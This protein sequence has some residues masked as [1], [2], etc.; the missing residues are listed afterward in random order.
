M[1]WLLRYQ[2]V[3]TEAVYSLKTGDFQTVLITDGPCHLNIKET[4]QD[5]KG[6]AGNNRKELSEKKPKPRAVS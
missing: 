3:E 6:S 2:P 5:Q 1:F 4:S